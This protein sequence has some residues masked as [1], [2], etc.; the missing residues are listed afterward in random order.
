MI[1]CQRLVLAGEAEQ[2][3]QQ[4]GGVSGAEA[5]AGEDLPVS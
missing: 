2:G 5:E 3:A 1:V 4:H